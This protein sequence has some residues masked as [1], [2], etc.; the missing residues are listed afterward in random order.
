M[1]RLPRKLKKELNKKYKH[2]YGI[3]RLKCDNIITEYYWF[4][5]NPFNWNMNKILN[6]KL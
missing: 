1:K 4:Y 5:K 6:N 3:D 2:R